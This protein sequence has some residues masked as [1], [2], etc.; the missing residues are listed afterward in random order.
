[1]KIPKTNYAFVD[2][3]F[4]PKTNTYGYGGFLVDP[5]GIKHI[6]MGSGNDPKIAKMRNVAGEIMGS[7]AAIKLAVK[8]GMKS[9]T[10]FYDYE[11]IAKWVT[12]SWK[13]K[14]KYTIEYRDYVKNTAIKHFL[15]IIFVH[16]RGHSGVAGNEEADRLAKQ[17]VGLSV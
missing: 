11:G 2:G 8:L 13:A 14:N 3:S 17:A 12:G 6:L 1:M 9:L 10:M 16:V 5:L 15:K 4:N 7:V